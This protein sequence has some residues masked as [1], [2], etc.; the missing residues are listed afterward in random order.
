VKSRFGIL[1]TLI[2]AGLFVFASCGGPAQPGSE[3]R[4]STG[5]LDLLTQ[6]MIGSFSSQEQ[7]EADPR[8][9]DI[10]LEMAPLWKG[11]RDGRWLYVEQAVATSLDEPYRQRVYRITQ[12]DATTFKST[13]YTFEEPLRFAGAWKQPEPLKDLSPADLTERT[14]CA[15]YLVKSGD[16]LFV[17]NTIGETCESELEGAAYATSEA[18]ISPGGLYTWDRGFDANGQQ[19]WGAQDGGYIFK[20]VVIEAE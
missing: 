20:R 19:V 4:G 16:S 13:V 8:Y 2:A 10:R 1:P 15:I 18:R 12:L 6:L 17:G 5:D 3:Q 9:F 14:G 11:R 7:S